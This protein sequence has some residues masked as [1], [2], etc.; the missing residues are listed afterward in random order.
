VY[1]VRLTGYG[2]CYQLSIC[3]RTAIRISD[4]VASFVAE[5]ANLFEYIEMI[6]M[7]R[8]VKNVACASINPNTCSAFVFSG[9]LVTTAL[10]HGKLRLIQVS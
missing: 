4:D 6:D 1:I 9:A 5:Q 3:H 2:K 10:H 7:I 8:N